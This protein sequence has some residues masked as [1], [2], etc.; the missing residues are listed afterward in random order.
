MTSAAASTAPDDTHAQVFNH[1]D[2][3]RN[4]GLLLVVPLVETY[5]FADVFSLRNSTS[6]TRYWPVP[7]GAFAPHAD[8]GLVAYDRP[9]T[10]L[11]SLCAE[12]Y[13]HIAHIPA[14]GATIGPS[15]CSVQDV[16]L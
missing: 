12:L 5:G 13:F 2:S 4:G 3:L 10:D 16:S 14:R 7:H 8:F 1:N 11:T 15:P 9:N 6:D